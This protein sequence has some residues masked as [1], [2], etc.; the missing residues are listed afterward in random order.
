MVTSEST[1]PKLGASVNR[2][3]ASA[4][5]HASAMWI[6]F[7]DQWDPRS[8]WH[9]RRV[10][11]AVNH[12]LDRKAISDTACL[13]YCPT[14]G[15]K[16]HAPEGAKLPPQDPFVAGFRDGSWILQDL[17]STNGTLLNGV[18]VGRCRLR[19]GDRIRLGTEELRID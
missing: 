14:A 12:A 1:P 16:L 5:R 15:W 19:P 13:G 18:R 11:L 4:T 9:D 2:F 6:E 3:S 10:R 8:P 7:A 17:E